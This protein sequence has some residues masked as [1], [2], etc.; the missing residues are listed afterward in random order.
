MLYYILLCNLCNVFW[1]TS[2]NYIWIKSRQLKVVFASSF[3]TRKQ[4]TTHVEEVI[5]LVYK[6]FTCCARCVVRVEWDHIEKSN[7][8]IIRTLLI[9]KRT[10]EFIKMHFKK[11]E[12]TNAFIWHI[13]TY[14]PAKNF[15][16]WW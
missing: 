7:S 10:S 3:Y 6:S 5:I 16:V 12:N 4:A 15:L 1:E 13:D 2:L 8:M 11:I 9:F 14:M